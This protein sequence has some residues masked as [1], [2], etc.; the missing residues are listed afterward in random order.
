VGRFQ[1]ASCLWVAGRAAQAESEFLQTLALDENFWLAAYG[2]GLHYSLAGRLAEAMSL[3]EKAYSVAPWSTNNIG[4]LAGVLQR[5]GNK[6]RAEELLQKLGDGQAHGA[7]GGLVVY[8]LVCSEIEKA[9]E[10]AEKAIEQRDP[11]IAIFYRFF[12]KAWRSS[13]RWPALAKRMN[14]AE[15][16]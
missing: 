2:L 6:N 7:P 4:L 1:L 3:A 14:L 16:D 15:A 13:P 10:W 9:A 12:M 8:H 5:S 11:R